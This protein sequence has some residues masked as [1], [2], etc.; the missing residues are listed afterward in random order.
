ML[1]TA[2]APLKTDC[3]LCPVRSCLVHRG[4]TTQ[5]GAWSE[6][7]APRQA[8]MPDD[9]A[10]H[11][12]GDRLRALYS[13]RGGCVKAFTV[14]AA[15][16]E[17]IRGFYFPGDLIGLDALAGGVALSTAVAVV[18]SQVCVAPL[19]D[20]NALMTE[21][22]GIALRVM[23][24]IS[25]ELALAMALAGEYTA[26]QRLA[27]FL[28][29]LRQRTGTGLDGCLRLPMAQRDV[30]NYLR[31]ANETVCRTLKRFEQKGWLTPVGR[32]LRLVD[33]AALRDAAAAVGIV[34]PGLAQTLAQAA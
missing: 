1:A 10:L 3:Q 33:E 9:G 20:L 27:A 25:R 32:G 29:Y 21:T 5:A 24:Q 4:D 26:E 12:A 16:N 15:G 23:E 28:L 18:P 13:V 31:L 22:P 7:L 2:A 30:G 8:L 14:D 6:M 34:K 19:A 11:R 17:R